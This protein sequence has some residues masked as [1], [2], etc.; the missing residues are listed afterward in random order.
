MVHSH[1]L[2]TCLNCCK[3]VLGILCEEVRTKSS[4]ST[5]ILHIDSTVGSVAEKVRRWT[6]I[7]HW[8]V[9]FVAV[10]KRFLGWLYCTFNSKTMNITQLWLSYS[11]GDG[12]FLWCKSVLVHFCKSSRVLENKEWCGS[13]HWVTH[14]ELSSWISCFVLQL[15]GDHVLGGLGNMLQL[16]GTD[17]PFRVCESNWRFASWLECSQRRFIIRNKMLRVKNRGPRYWDNVCLAT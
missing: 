1:A 9:A 4:E 11:S 7:S 3:S 17:Y 5:L 13:S 14:N 15:K 12:T 8:K 16:V 2:G 6:W 10:V